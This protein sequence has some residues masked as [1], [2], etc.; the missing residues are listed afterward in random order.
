MALIALDSN[1][2][3]AAWSGLEDH[4]DIAAELLLSVNAGHDSAIYSTLV[5]AEVLAFPDRRKSSG[6]SVT[7]FFTQLSNAQARPVDTAIASLAG[8]LRSQY[9]AL[10]LAD[11]IH[12]AT[13]LNGK[14]AILV[15]ND[16]QLA[17]I[18]KKLMPTE[19]LATY[20]R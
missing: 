12:L 16:R 11:S 15:T 1:V 4:S 18:T 2:F 10:R 17:N 13:A 8:S 6:L 14:A 20:K 9:P 5:L 7:D 19:T 3:I